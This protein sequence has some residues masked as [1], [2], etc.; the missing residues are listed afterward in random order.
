M[1]QDKKQSVRLSD[2]S[3]IYECFLL[4]VYLMPKMSW[5]FTYYV[6][7]SCMMLFERFYAGYAFG[8]G[9]KVLPSIQPLVAGE[10]PRLM[11]ILGA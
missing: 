1:S 4:I 8:C 6:C 5:M 3:L 9:N 11:Y 2:S 10:S 7:E